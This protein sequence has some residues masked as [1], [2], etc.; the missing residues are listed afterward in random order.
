ME[1]EKL[2]LSRE[3]WEFFKN[4]KEIELTRGYD[5]EYLK[6]TVVI[7]LL[8]IIIFYITCKF[9]SKQEN[10]GEPQL[11]LTQHAQKRSD[12]AFD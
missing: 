9:N 11:G 6:L 5:L 3:Q 1:E 4:M 10:Y 7:T 12:P 2:K 8:I